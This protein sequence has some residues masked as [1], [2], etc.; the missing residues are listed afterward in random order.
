MA[1]KIAIKKEKED[2]Y[3]EESG[4]IFKEGNNT[5]AN[6]YLTASDLTTVQCT[7]LFSF[8][9]DKFIKL[10]TARN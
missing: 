10:L 8:Q 1:V 3:L 2:F 5:K 7:S 4:E 6:Y 9:Q